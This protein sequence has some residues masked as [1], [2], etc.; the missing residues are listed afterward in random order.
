MMKSYL[1]IYELNTVS[2]NTVNVIQS[3]VLSMA[4]DKYRVR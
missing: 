4:S 1:I 2:D 3:F